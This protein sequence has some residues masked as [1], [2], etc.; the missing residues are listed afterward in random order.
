VV[1]TTTEQIGF[2]FESDQAGPRNFDRC[3][4]EGV[5]ASRLED[6][7]YWTKFN[8][9]LKGEIHYGIGAVKRKFEDPAAISLPHTHTHTVHNFFLSVTL[10]GGLAENVFIVNV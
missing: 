3:L 1:T 5:T 4:A 6:S 9:L 2:T 7:N 8:A 10:Q